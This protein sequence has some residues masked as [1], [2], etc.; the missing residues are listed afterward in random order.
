MAACSA[1]STGLCQGST[2]TAEPTR[3]IWVRAAIHVSRFSVAETWFHPE[4]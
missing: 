2:I 1:R 4:K 3:S